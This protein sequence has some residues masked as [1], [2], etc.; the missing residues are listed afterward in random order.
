MKTLHAGA[1]T[2]SNQSWCKNQKHRILSSD[3]F[4]RVLIK[5]QEVGIMHMGLQS[6][7]T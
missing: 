3:F 2:P 7:Y 6:A 4:W 5:M 1:H